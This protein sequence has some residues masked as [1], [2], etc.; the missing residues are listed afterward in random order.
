MRMQ[1]LRLGTVAAGLLTLQA[2]QTPSQPSYLEVRDATQSL[3]EIRVHLLIEFC[4]GQTPQ[5]VSV[6]E[7][8]TWPQSA[9][10][11][12]VANVAQWLAAGCK[13]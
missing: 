8:N 2:C 5:S 11:M 4:R 9:K 10:D 1:L 12:A 13:L 3:D 7:F 6:D